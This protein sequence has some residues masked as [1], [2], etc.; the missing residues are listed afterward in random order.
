MPFA[1]NQG[2]RIHYEVEG[3]GPPL[4][5]QYG[6]YFPL[7]VWYEYNYVSALQNHFQLILVDGRGQ[8]ESDKP[9]DP[10]AYCSERMVKDIL[11]VLDDLGIKKTHYM[12]YSSGGYLGFGIAKYASER[13]L[14][15]ILGGTH[16]YLD[17]NGQFN[18]NEER[19]R[20]LE[21]QNTEQFV[22]GLEG[23][24]STQNF[25]PLSPRLRAKMSLHDI[26]ALI[27]WHKLNEF[28]NIEEVF[29]AISVP[30][31]FYAGENS[32]EFVNAQRTAQNIRGAAFVTIPGG[33]H[34][35]GGTWIKLLKPHILKV[36]ASA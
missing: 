7:D 3:K 19:I 27:A 14:S 26:Q 4:V 25:P 15:L 30:C 13:C 11:A 8:G 6:Q 32:G 10:E 31:L 35:E 28:L 33:G 24:L 16:L 29:G 12:G 36:T 5:L 9:H 23:F 34:L 17:L 20:D 21:K 1:N 2:I 22:T 18:W